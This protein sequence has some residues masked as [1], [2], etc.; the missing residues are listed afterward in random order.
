RGGGGRDDRREGL[1]RRPAV[2]L[3]Q[4]SV[5]NVALGPPGAY[6]MSAVQNADEII[7]E[8]PGVAVAVHL[9]RLRVVQAVAG[10]DEGAQ[11]FDVGR[12]GSRK[13]VRKGR[14]EQL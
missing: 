13:Q 4:L 14:A 5:G 10:L 9:V 11:V 12:I 3:D 2:L 1:S 8:V 7:E 6:H